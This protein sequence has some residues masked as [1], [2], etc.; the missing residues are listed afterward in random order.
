MD[1]YSY[2]GTEIAAES[3][4]V[5]LMSSNLFGVCNA[6]ALSRFVWKRIVLNYVWAFG[7]N[8]LGILHKS[9]V[10]VVLFYFLPSRPSC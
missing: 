6:L 1:S 5:V 2:V 8:V 10:D 9:S 3:A 7:F 4:D